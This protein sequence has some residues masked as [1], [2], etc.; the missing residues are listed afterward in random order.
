MLLM[1][2]RHSTYLFGH[3][4]KSG[5]QLSSIRVSVCWLVKPAMQSLDLLITGLDV[6]LS[7]DAFVQVAACLAFWQ[8]MSDRK[9]IDLAGRSASVVVLYTS[10]HK[11]VATRH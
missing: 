8:E 9:T 6:Q 3:A 11:A 7:A 2:E 5:R 10:G 1:S 4:Y